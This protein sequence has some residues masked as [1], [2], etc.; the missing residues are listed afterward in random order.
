MKHIPKKTKQDIRR[1]WLSPDI[2][3]VELAELFGITYQEAYDIIME[4]GS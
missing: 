2:G 1:V 4:T 3:L